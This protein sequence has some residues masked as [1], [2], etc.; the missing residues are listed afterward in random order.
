LKAYK[1]LFSII[2]FFII[3]SCNIKEK[4]L[5]EGMIF[6]NGGETYVGSNSFSLDEAPQTLKNVKGFY[7][8]KHPVTVKQFSDFV[9]ATGYITEAENFGNSAVFNFKTGSWSLKDGATWRYPQGRDFPKAI[10][11]HPVTQVSWN[12]AMAYCNWIGKRLPTEVEWEHAARNAG[13]IREAIYP[14]NSNEIKK[15]EDYLA[16]FWQGPFPLYNA[17]EDG[18]EITSPVGAFGETP[19]GLQDIVGN[20]WEW[21]SNWKV[22][23]MDSTKV[24]NEKVQRGGSFLCD[25]NVC[26]GYRVSARSSSTPESALMNV[27]FRCV[28]DVD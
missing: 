8:D 21:C 22:S 25:P 18:Y 14:W 9:E 11:N 6:I 19:L 24:F 13:T 5:T 10:G 12:D 26:Y 27:G 1:C 15:G 3:Y 20:V 28:K 4:Q 2:T 23:Y 16:N 17:V 7:M